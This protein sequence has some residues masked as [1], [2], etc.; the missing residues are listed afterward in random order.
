MKGDLTYAR[1]LQI[2]CSDG[3]YDRCWAGEFEVRFAFVGWGGLYL[4]KSRS[5]SL[6]WV[7]IFT[8]DG[9]RKEMGLGSLADV[10]LALAREKAD[11]YRSVLARGDCPLAARRATREALTFK[12]CADEWEAAFGGQWKN[13]GSRGEYVRCV[14]YCRSIWNV[15]I[16]ELAVGDVLRVVKGVSD[17]PTVAKSVLSIIRRVVTFAAAH[18]HRSLD[19]VNPA[20]GL[21][22]GSIVSLKAVRSHHAAMPY[23]QVGE[24]VKGL[25]STDAVSARALEMIVLCGARKNEVLGMRFDEIDGDVWTVPAHKMKG[26]VAHSVPLTA[27]AIEIVEKQRRRLGRSDGLVFPSS[28][29]RALSANAFRHLMTGEWTVHGFRSSF[30]S[31]AGDCTDHERETCELAPAHRIG[32]GV[33]QAYRRTTALAKRTALMRDWAAYLDA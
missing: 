29:G 5:G 26:G 30:R 14:G 18:G 22:I 11:E 7:F 21:L 20:D 10:S 16:G 33:E 12:A 1:S 32:N 4:F 17:R 15:G 3:R 2:K 31:W 25:R 28:H 23:Q 27:R 19:V 13:T 8:R 6:T 9:V 24:F